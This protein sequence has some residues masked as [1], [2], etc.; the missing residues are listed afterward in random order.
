GDRRHGHGLRLVVV[1][2]GARRS[3]ARAPRETTGTGSAP[4][5]PVTL[6]AADGS[7]RTEGSCTTTRSQPALRHGNGRGPMPVS[8][9]PHLELLGEHS[10]GLL[11][12]HPAFRA[13]C[14]CA[15]STSPRW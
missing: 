2:A 10:L 11:D 3:N 12:D 15:L 7:S 8:V 13:V 5:A 4:T 6:P 14:S 9:H 1:Q